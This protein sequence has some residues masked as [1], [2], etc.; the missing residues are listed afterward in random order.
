MKMTVE[1]ETLTKHGG[2]GLIDNIQTD[3]AAPVNDRVGGEAE[4]MIEVQSRGKNVGSSLQFIY[5]GMEDLVHEPDTW[6]LEWV[7]LR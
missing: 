4:V 6:T 7:L 2:P 1:C 5:I 3:G